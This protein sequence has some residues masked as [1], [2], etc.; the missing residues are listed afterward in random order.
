MS[1]PDASTPSGQRAVR[2]WDLPTRWFHWLLTAAIVAQVVTGKIGGAA[3]QWHLRIGYCVF[4][5]LLFRLVWGFVGGHWSRFASFVYGPGSVLRYLRGRPAAGDWFHVGHNPLGSVSVFA[6]LALLALQV[7]TGL[8]ADDEIATTGPLNRYVSSAFALGA[9]AW[10]KGPGIALIVVLV[11]LHVGAIAYY[12]V[13]KGQNLVAPMLH[14]DKQLAGAVPASD[15]SRA[16]RVRA[17]AVAVACAGLVT[18]VVGL[19]G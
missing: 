17:L 9:T 14:G 8:V 2:V 6:M 15:D 18:A 5:L 7:A 12:R 13:R 1:D 10:H 4:G 16:T 19:G 11:L 3:L